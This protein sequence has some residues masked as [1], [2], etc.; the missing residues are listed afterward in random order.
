[1]TEILVQIMAEVL[2]IVGL[3][4][5]DVSRGRSKKYLKK[6]VGNTEIEDSLQKLDKLTQE[7]ARMAAAEHMRI[8]RSIEGRVMGVNDNVMGVEEGVQDVRSEV[9]DVR[10]RVQSVDDKVEDVGKIVQDVDKRVQSVGERVQ[11]VNRKLD[12]V[13]RS[14]SLHYSSFRFLKYSH[15]KSAQR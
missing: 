12:Q 5:K 10:K 1:M 4:T 2:V 3:A 15:R 9:E 6:L 7:E 8:T 13:N 14:S 11:D